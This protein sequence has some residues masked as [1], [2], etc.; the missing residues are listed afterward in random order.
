MEKKSTR[1]AYLV[2]VAAIVVL[3]AVLAMNYKDVETG[4][5]GT[6]WALLPPVVAIALALIS[7]EV[8]SSLF[9]G[10]LVGSLLYT[11]FAPW[12][13]IV[14]LVGGDYG[15]VTTVSDSYNMGIIV[16]LVMLGIIVDLMNKGGG[17]EAFGRWANTSV[18]TRCGAQLMSMLLGCLIFIDDY[19]N[20][21]TV[22]AVMRPVTESHKISRA[23]LAYV[24]DATAAPV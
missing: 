8:Y 10:C 24:I 18:K 14:Q 20:C 16:F 7:K 11:Q 15:I 5:V 22:G 17:S 4:F 9:V 12:E 13:A 23:K 6:C 2:A 1:T 3:L 19:F 21:L